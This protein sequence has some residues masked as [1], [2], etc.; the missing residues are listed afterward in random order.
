[1]SNVTVHG[2]CKKCGQYIMFTASM[3]ADAWNGYERKLKRHNCPTPLR[4]DSVK[5]GDSNQ[6]APVKSESDSPA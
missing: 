1:M 2:V 5:A 6:P 3:K 4:A